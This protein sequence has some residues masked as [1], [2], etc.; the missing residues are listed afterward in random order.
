MQTY[1]I[2][3]QLEDKSYKEFLVEAKNSTF[4]QVQATQKIFPKKAI[5]TMVTLCAG[6]AA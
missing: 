2:I 5:M 6:G 4:A 1:N 3:I